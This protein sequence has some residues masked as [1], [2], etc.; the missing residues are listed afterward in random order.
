MTGETKY[1]LRLTALTNHLTGSSST[2]TT[3]EPQV[4]YC[5]VTARLRDYTSKCAMLLDVD[6][7]I[8]VELSGFNEV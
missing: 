7:S 2:G 6:L 1:A 8:L 4:S 5:F 3:L